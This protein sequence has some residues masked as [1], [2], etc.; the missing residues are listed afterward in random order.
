MQSS[1]PEKLARRERLKT[2][3][4]WILFPILLLA[5]IAYFTIGRAQ[6]VG[7]S[8]APTL[9]PGQRLTVLKAFRL[10]SPLKVGDVVVIATG[11]GKG[12]DLEVVKRVVFIQNDSGTAA[13]PER[14]TS[15]VGAY[16]TAECFPENGP[17][18]KNVR[19]GIYVLGDNINNSLDSREFGAIGEREVIGKVLGIK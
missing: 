19:N 6:V 14:L 15:P 2:I 4:R 18:A 10:F 3:E 16:A 12:R 9:A 1:D 5:A 8:M 17:N 7:M 13:W 11:S